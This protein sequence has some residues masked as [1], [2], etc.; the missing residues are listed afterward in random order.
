MLH[1]AGWEA[2]P[3]RSAGQSSSSQGAEGSGEH[4]G[5][6]SCCISAVLCWSIFFLPPR[7]STSSSALPAGHQRLFILSKKTAELH[8][9]IRRQHPMDDLA[10]S[11]MSEALCLSVPLGDSTCLSVFIRWALM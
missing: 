11:W 8:L 6:F 7:T 9:K 4:A 1:L 10:A 3:E 2:Q 5:D